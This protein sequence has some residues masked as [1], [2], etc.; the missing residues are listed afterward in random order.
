[1]ADLDLGFQPTPSQAKRPAIR[2]A[3]TFSPQD[4][5]E[6]NT[7]SAVSDDLDVLLIELER[8][9]TDV[10]PAM[11]DQIFERALPLSTP[12][13]SA[14]SSQ[15]LLPPASEDPIHV[16]IGRMLG[17]LRRASTYVRTHLPAG[18]GGEMRSRFDKHHLLALVF[19]NDDCWADL[20]ADTAT[21]RPTLR[22]SGC[23]TKADW[24]KWLEKLTHVRTQLH[25]MAKH[26]KTLWEKSRRDF[27]VA[28]ATQEGRAGK[29]QRAMHMIFPNTSPGMAD[30][31]FWKKV[32]VEHSAGRE[33][34]G[35]MAVRNRSEAG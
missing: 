4:W 12:D 32:Q 3:H 21:M 22:V 11:L 18:R 6:L 33:V 25:R 19:H 28:K 14:G 10:D 31:A 16:A 24:L 26:H 7:D 2:W 27:E 15:K 13:R 34:G 35:R 5:H 8:A 23:L 9:G 1:V 29:L 30:N 20:L 17:R